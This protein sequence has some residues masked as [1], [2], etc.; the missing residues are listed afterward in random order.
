VV[1]TTDVIRCSATACFVATVVAA[2][3]GYFLGMDPNALLGV[4]GVEAAA[5]GVGEASNI[6]K[7]ATFKREA[8]Q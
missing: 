1:K 7:R 4:L 6:G 2:V 3:L 8:V 5:M